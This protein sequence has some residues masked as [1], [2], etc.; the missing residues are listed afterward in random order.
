[1]SSELWS[2]DP[3]TFAWYSVNPMA[4]VFPVARKFH[5]MTSVGNRAFLFGGKTHSAC[6]ALDP[7]DD[8]DEPANL[9]PCHFPFTWRNN[10]YFAC[11]DVDW[12]QLWCS[13]SEDGPELEIAFVRQLHC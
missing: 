8:S 5:A 9:G 4:G 2:Y 10:E 7:E 6:S 3:I 13:T 12:D 1:V 11:T